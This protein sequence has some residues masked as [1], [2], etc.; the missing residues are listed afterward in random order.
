MSQTR[1]IYAPGTTVSVRRP[2]EPDLVGQVIYTD[3][4]GICV[5]KTYSQGETA[6]ILVPW[7]EVLEV[8]A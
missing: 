5:L 6:R 8:A 2:D 1:D 4:H 7:G 3:M